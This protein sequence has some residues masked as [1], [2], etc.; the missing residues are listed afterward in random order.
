MIYDQA[1]DLFA[2]ETLTA[3]GF[4]SIDNKRTPSKVLLCTNLDIVAATEC[5]KNPTTICTTSH[6]QNNVCSGDFGGPLFYQREDK[7]FVVAGIA[8]YSPDMKNQAP[9][10]DEHLTAFTRVA[11]FIDW[12]ISELGLDSCYDC[13]K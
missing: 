10:L 7:K 13:K 1:A 3:C 2:G 11:F 6:G 8:T 5:D 4:G 12:I 9:C